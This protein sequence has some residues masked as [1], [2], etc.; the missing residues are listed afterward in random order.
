MRFR[1]EPLKCEWHLLT[2][3]HEARFRYAALIGFPNSDFQTMFSYLGTRHSHVILRIEI[4]YY[5]TRYTVTWGQF[6]AIQYSENCTDPIRFHSFDVSATIETSS[7]L[8][9]DIQSIWRYMRNAFDGTLWHSTRYQVPGTR[10]QVTT[11]LVLN[12]RKRHAEPNQRLAVTREI[13][14]W[15]PISPITRMR[16]NWIP[17]SLARSF[18][19]SLSFS[20]APFTTLCWHSD[21]RERV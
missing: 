14:G 12:T 6:G 5:S 17:P 2:T 11:V 1:V 15:F 13:E 8:M 10:Y 3:I 16:R 21:K 20:L 9:H 7:V 19:F 18:S 4:T